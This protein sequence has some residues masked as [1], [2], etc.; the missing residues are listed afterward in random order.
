MSRIRIGLSS[1][2]DKSMLKSEKFYPP[3]VKG[4]A[5]AQ[6]RYY[7]DQ[8]PDLV[9][10]NSSYYALPS[11]RNAGLWAERTPDGFVFDIKLYRLFTQHPTPPRP[12]PTDVK[13]A[14]PPEVLDKRNLYFR[15]VPDELVAELMAR[16]VAALG[17]LEQASK[18][19]AVL[20]QFPHWF[21]PGEESLQHLAWLQEHLGDRQMA[22][23]FR[24]GLWMDTE[25][26]QDTLSFLEERGLT[27]VCVDEP[28]G[29]RSSV[30][31]VVA[32]TSS[33]LAYVRFHG[34]RQETWEKSG[35]GVAE[36]FRYLYDEDELSEWVPRV[37]SLAEVA[38]EVHVLFNNNYEDYPVRNARQLRL[39]LE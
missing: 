18:L 7:A 27:Y 29:H 25:H 32:A 5:E 37:K 33:A 3:D 24:N 30:P 34:R 15:D 20:A 26:R 28:Q 2:T 6:L 21:H 19:G 39:L 11:A 35:V 31:P 23:E 9:E 17:P 8:F 16:Y 38:D 13:E 4:D 14:L 36:R 10:V 12:L 1:W 22:V